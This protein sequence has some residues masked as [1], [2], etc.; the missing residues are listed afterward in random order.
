MARSINDIYNALLIEKE[1]NTTLTA[2]EP[3]AGENA[4]NLLANLS[5]GSKVAIW[6]LLFWMVAFA[7]YMH[8]TF[9]DLFVA[10]VAN[11]EKKIHVGTPYWFWYKTLNFQLGDTLSW[12]SGDYYGYAVEDDTKKIIKRCAV[13][14]GLGL[15]KIKVAKLSGTTPVKLITS[16]LNAYK[17]YINLL[18]PAGVNIE[19]ISIDADLLKLEVSVKVDEQLIDST[20]QQVGGTSYPVED[21]INSYIGNLPFNGLFYVA[22][23]VDAIQAVQGVENVHVSVAE[24]KSYTSGYNAIDPVLGYIPKAG[25]LE[26]DPL[27]PLNTQISYI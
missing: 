26:I 23:L 12:L 8:E 5:S 27:Y 16:E 17:D 6:R 3:N 1:A 14:D 19:V 10:D 22:S 2:L 13:E 4:T 15:L 25:Y 21:A 24:A 7:I 11:A 20:G 18:K 9:F